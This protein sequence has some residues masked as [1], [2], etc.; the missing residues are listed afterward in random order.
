MKINPKYILEQ[1]EQSARRAA[2]Y[3]LNKFSEAK[4]E[5]YWTVNSAV[6]HAISEG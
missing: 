3:M 5:D 1:K 4:K 2:E 6:Q